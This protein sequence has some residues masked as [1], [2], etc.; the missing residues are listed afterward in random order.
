MRIRVVEERRPAAGQEAP[1]AVHELYTPHISGTELRIDP[2][3]PA[4]M[5]GRAQAVGVA[6]ARLDTL[7]LLTLGVLAGAF[8]ALGAI[9]ATTVA[10]G[11]GVPYGV[12]RLLAGLS[13]I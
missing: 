5:A 11:D 9:F 2:Y 1:T 10:S 3:G 6:K 8:I 12:T 13:T 4:E 7:T